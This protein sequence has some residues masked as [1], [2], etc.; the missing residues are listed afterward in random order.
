MDACFYYI[1]Q[2]AK[3]SKNIKYKATTTNFWFQ[4][5]IK[6]I[7]PTF[8]KDPHVLMSKLSLVDIVTGNSLPLSTPWANVDYV[9]MPILPTNMAHWMLGVLQFRSHTLTVFNS[10]DKSYRDWKV[11]QAIKPYV[12]ILHALMNALEISNKDPNYHGPG[13]V[14]L[15]S[16]ST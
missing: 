6:D 4:N 5:K 8:A 1:H 3:H 9:F 13:C 12:K 10:I 16:S 15:R 7:Y 2:L 14:E 11:L